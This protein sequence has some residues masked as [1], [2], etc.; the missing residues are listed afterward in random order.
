[1]FKIVYNQFKGIEDYSTSTGI[2]ANPRSP[3]AVTK[4]LQRDHG[5]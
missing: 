1:M 4:S 3:E 2:G 5:G